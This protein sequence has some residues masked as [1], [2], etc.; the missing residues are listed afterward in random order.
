MTY[1]FNYSTYTLLVGVLRTHIRAFYAPILFL[2]VSWYVKKGLASGI[3]LTDLTHV[4]ANNFD[5]TKDVK[6]IHITPHN[7][8]SLF[9]LYVSIYFTLD[10][11]VEAFDWFDRTSMLTTSQYSEGDVVVYKNIGYSFIVDAKTHPT[12]YAWMFHF[13]DYINKLATDF[14]AYGNVDE[15]EVIITRGRNIS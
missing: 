12:L 11:G 2:V 7:S 1:I 10:I 14:K 5:A 8:M 4:S 6:S 3:R 13:L 15:I 9:Q